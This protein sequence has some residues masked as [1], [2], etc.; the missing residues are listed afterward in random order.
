MRHVS[1]MS[2]KAMK[3]RVKL[4]AKRNQ[5]VHVFMDTG[6]EKQ[7]RDLGRRLLLFFFFL[8]GYKA[9]TSAMSALHIGVLQCNLFFLGLVR[10]CSLV[11]RGR[12][13]V[14]A[15]VGATGVSAR[16]CFWL[17]GRSLSMLFRSCLTAMDRCWLDR[18]NLVYLL[19]AADPPQGPP[20]CLLL[21]SGWLFLSLHF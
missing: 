14:R 5:I 1:A 6:R 2:S 3:P 20:A 9:I 16:C 19:D 11:G 12:F 15:M 18:D 17:S 13:W 10:R 7:A 8:P 21:L 4:H